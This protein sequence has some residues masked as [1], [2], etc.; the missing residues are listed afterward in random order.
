MLSR[1]QVFLFCPGGGDASGDAGAEAEELQS[2]RLSMVAD[3]ADD[4]VR[5]ESYAVTVFEQEGALCATDP[6]VNEAAV[7]VRQPRTPLVRRIAA[8]VQEHFERRPHTPLVAI[9]GGTP[10]LSSHHVARAFALLE[11][12]DDVVVVAEADTLPD[13]PVVM[14]GMKI[15]HRGILLR[16]G[17][18]RIAMESIVAADAVIIPL[19]P[20]LQ[21][22]RAHDLDLLRHEVERRML[23]DRPVPL[24]TRR[25]LED[26]R[27]RA[28]QTDGL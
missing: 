17:A 1:S 19:R 11:L 10:L 22:S 25:W 27:R 6:P 23:L 28:L 26:H 9:W 12:E 5:R 18:T 7:R 14:V 8:S 21:I 2:L 20:V 15:P 13:P 24:R 16:S 4:L 3:L